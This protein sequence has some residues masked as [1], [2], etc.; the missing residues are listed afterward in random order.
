MSDKRR[1]EFDKEDIKKV[2]EAM[3]GDCITYD[4][5]SDD[6]SCDFCSGHRVYQQEKFVHQL[7]CPVLVAQDLLTGL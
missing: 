1:A 6:Y 5:Y 7:D 4:G 2:A 3:V